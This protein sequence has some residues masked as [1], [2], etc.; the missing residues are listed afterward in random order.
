MLHPIWKAGLKSLAFFILPGS[1]RMM[2]VSDRTWSPWSAQSSGLPSMA[3]STLGMRHRG[4][5]GV[6]WVH[7]AS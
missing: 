6:T 1:F 3:T 7:A 5:A 2:P 4:S